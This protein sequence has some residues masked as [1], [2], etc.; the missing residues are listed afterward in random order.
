MG[1]GHGEIVA[2]RPP[3]QG[4]GLK[5]HPNLSAQPHWVEVGD[6]AAAVED[7]ALVGDLEPAAQPQ[8]SGLADTGWPGDDRDSTF[9]DLAADPVE[10][11]T[12]CPFNH[13]VVEDERRLSDGRL[14][15]HDRQVRLF[16]SAPANGIRGA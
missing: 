11:A 13:D 3:K 14:G 4:R 16:A 9:R 10:H 15:G 2:D 8:E 12:T 1:V 7:V 5:H 6:V